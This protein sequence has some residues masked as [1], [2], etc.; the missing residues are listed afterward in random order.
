MAIITISRDSYSHGKEIAEEVARKLGYS[1]ISRE[2]L[3]EASEH[4][5]IPEVKLTRALHDAP[6][7]LDRLTYGREKYIAFI[8]AEF[9]ERVRK[10][11]IVY[12]GLA[13]HFM[14]CDVG[15]CLK[16]RVVADMDDRV[17]LEMQRENR[18][19]DDALRALKKDDEERR[20]WSWNLWGHDPWDSVLYDIILHVNKLTI[21][22]AV[23]IICLASKMEHFATTP[24]S[25]RAVEDLHL[26]AKVK[27]GLVDEYPS[28]TVKAEGGVVRVDVLSDLSQEARIIAEI[29]KL[30]AGLS[31]VEDVR[32]SV[33][34]HGV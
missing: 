32:V 10:D 28:C 7:I 14:L 24:D 1:C 20:K 3:L 18:S 17:N 9:L 5:N 26:A 15:H 13:G 16:V 19:S 6:A 29:E 2:V 33:T 4:F 34:P 12:H 11:N 25:Q 22:N 23:D 8:Q 30:T 27:T 31:G 21:A